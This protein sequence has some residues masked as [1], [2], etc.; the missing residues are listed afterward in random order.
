MKK[1]LLLM[2][3]IGVGCAHERPIPTVI[4]SLDYA[5]Q[6]P[7]Q[8]SNDP[9][10]RAAA[11]GSGTEAHIKLV[12]SD[13]VTNSNPAQDQGG[14]F[15][16]DV[17][18]HRTAN[19]ML[20][21]YQGPLALGDPGVGASLWKESR[22]SNDM[23]RDDRALLP[24]DLVTI[25]VEEKDQGSRQAKTD[26][27]SETSLAAALTNFFGLEVFSKDANPSID[28]SAIVSA[29]STSEFK[30]EGK[31]DRKNSLTAKISAMVAEV[32]P[33]GILRIEGKKIVAVNDEEQIMIISGLVRTRD[34]SSEN[35]VNSS[36]I[37]NMRI[38]YYGKGVVD[39]AQ[40][41]GWGTRLIRNVWPF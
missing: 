10:V 16:E 17:Q 5:K 9:I 37:A 11:A 39:E 35:E 41:V 21:D 3:L 29:E 24:G 14:E 28:P 22:G 7:R 23:L 26:T 12:Q 6:F 38:D 36:K 40:R 19:A 15:I 8:T 18:I 25:V 1:S 34:V 31:T 30:G 4:P 13:T 2:T 20:R 27:K 32:L 33:T